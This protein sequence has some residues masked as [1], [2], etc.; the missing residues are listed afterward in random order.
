M[1]AKSAT[2]FIY[3]VSSMGTTGVRSEFTINLT[4]IVAQIR[5]VTSIPIMI[6]FGIST[7]EQAD[8]MREIAD[9]VIVGSALVRIIAEHG[10]ESAP[11][12]K[13][14]IKEMI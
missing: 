4:D 10:D 2:G 9:G 13:K 12:L 3:L 7:P 11:Y 6:G 1:L 14:F 8:K 5:E